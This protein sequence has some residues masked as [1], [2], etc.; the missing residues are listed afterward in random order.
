MNQASKI[1]LDVNGKDLK[2]NFEQYLGNTH[3]RT[4]SKTGIHKPI[5]ARMVKMI[6]G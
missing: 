2:S 1:F 5:A 3:I 6:P 4:A